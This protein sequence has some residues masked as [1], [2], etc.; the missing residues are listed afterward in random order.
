MPLK[1][2]GLSEDKHS[3]ETCEFEHAC[4]PLYGHIR[5]VVQNDIDF[6]NFIHFQAS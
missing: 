3:L 1:C 2:N 6:T 4:H 5:P